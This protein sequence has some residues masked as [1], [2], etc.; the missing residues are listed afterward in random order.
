MSM[1]DQ[2]YADRP[3]GMDVSVPRAR[4]DTMTGTQGRAAPMDSTQR[5]V[6]SGRGVRRVRSRHCAAACSCWPSSSAVSARGRISLWRGWLTF[7]AA[8]LL[9]PVER[10]AVL[11][12]YGYRRFTAREAA[13]LDSACRYALQRCG[14]GAYQIDFYVRRRSP[15]VNGYA[16]GRRS[17]AVTA[18][19]VQA[20]EDG[21]LSDRQAA[22]IMIHEIGACC[23][24][25]HPLR[26]GHRLVDRAVARSRGAVPRPA[27][28][29][30]ATPAHRS[31]PRCCWPR[32]SAPW[33]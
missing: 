33:P 21:R 9:R 29:D 31:V 15:A 5:G 6:M 28:G 7:A 20:L 17:V 4:I 3:F 10:S 14:V 16:A 27:A 18:G 19:L 23:R 8:L 30:P 13:L 32:S 11:I 1:T 22:A 2:R 25:S 24:A 12:A 26:T